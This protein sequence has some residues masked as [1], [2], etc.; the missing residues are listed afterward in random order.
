[1]SKSYTYSHRCRLPHGVANLRCMHAAF[2][3]K[4]ASCNLVY[5]CL[6]CLH[7]NVASVVYFAK[8]SRSLNAY[9]QNIHHGEK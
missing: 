6:P 2:L 8:P 9:A 3:L 4:I 1:M 7:F 5:L